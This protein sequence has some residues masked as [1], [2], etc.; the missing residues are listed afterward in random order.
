MANSEDSENKIIKEYWKELKNKLDRKLG[1]IP[2]QEQTLN[3]L[4]LV[5]KAISGIVLVI[6]VSSA[7]YAFKSTEDSDNR[8]QGIT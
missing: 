1:K 2:W 5:T 7:L 3:W 4:T 6:G 8:D